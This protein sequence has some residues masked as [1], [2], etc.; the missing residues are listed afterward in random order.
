[1]PKVG[2]KSNTFGYLGY[3]PRWTY[4]IIYR[5]SYHNVKT[6]LVDLVGL[7]RLKQNVVEKI[8]QG[9]LMLGWVVTI[10]SD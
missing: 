5:F 4:E 3:Y 7:C 1:M 10:D 9:K 2:K 8:C 6:G